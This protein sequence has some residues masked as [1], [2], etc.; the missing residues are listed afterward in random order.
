[1]QESYS[2]I[3]ADVKLILC[4]RQFPFDLG[5]AGFNIISYTFTQRVFMSDQASHI[6]H[7][8][9]SD[10]A[11][12]QFYIDAGVNETIVDEVVNRFKAVEPVAA[13]EAAPALENAPSPL[14]QAAASAPVV[15][16]KS[17]AQMQAASI[18]AAAG[19]LDELREAI[20]GFD[21]ISLKKTATNLVFEAGNREASIMVIGDSPGT[22][23]DRSGEAFVGAAGQLL[24]KILKC[25]DLERGAE[26]ADKAAYLANLLN[27]RPPG[28]RAPN[29]SEIAVSLPFIERQ[30]QLVQPKLIILLG[31]EPA[32]A[33]LG[34]TESISR[35]RKKWHD[36][37]PQTPELQGADVKAIPAI[38]TY[39]PSYL[40]STPL[41][42]KAVWA[43]MLSVQARHKP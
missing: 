9:A 43:D 24:D 25:V 30:I 21:G 17:E 34:R 36:Y 19:T 40:L 15:V 42:K 4:G 35:L 6:P 37:L 14:V 5:S 32:K 23:E 29:A 10:L 12:L 22:E 20:A 28:N 2:Q 11:A 26:D 13:V 33:L 27:W 18:A 8:I 1:L 7:S 31:G 39:H 16:G 3:C 41:Q 38:A